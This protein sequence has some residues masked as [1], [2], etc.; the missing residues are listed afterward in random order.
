MATQAPSWRHLGAQLGKKSIARRPKTDQDLTRSAKVAPS[1][2]QDDPRRPNI[3]PEATKSMIL[4]WSGK[5]FATI[6]P[7]PRRCQRPRYAQGHSATKR[8]LLLKA[9]A[10][11]AG[12]MALWSLGGPSATKRRV[13]VE[14]AR[15]ARPNRLHRKPFGR[16]PARDEQR[17]H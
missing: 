1:P 17:S 9:R 5:D 2:G 11:R 16:H 12:S 7:L 3:I 6:G 10:R 8:V 15:K 13:Y 14:S 4:E